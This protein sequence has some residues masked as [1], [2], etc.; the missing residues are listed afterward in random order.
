[1]KN[2]ILLSAALCLCACEARPN[3][4]EM[5]MTNG[6]LGYKLD[7]DNTQF[8]LQQCSAEAHRICGDKDVDFVYYREDSRN[9]AVRCLDN[10]NK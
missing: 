9:A 8:T 10:T 7:C 4:S 1:M 6:E 3:H 5:K 2:I